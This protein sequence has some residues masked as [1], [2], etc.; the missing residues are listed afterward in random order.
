M[1]ILSRGWS[2][3]IQIPASSSPVR[4]WKSWCRGWSTTRSSWRSTT[5]RSASLEWF[6]MWRD[7]MIKC[8]CGNNLEVF[9]DYGYNTY[10]WSFEIS[11]AGPFPNLFFIAIHRVSRHLV[12]QPWV[13]VFIPP[14]LLRSNYSLHVCAVYFEHFRVLNWNPINAK[15]IPRL[16]LH[17]FLHLFFL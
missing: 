16:K 4:S 2:K 8:Q 10:S 1:C 9:N 15:L 5:G 17:L 3:W 7:M 13:V 11:V 14:I 12:I 6:T